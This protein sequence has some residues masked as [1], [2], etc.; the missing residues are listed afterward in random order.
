MVW[1]LGYL[2]VCRQFALIVPHD[3]ITAMTDFSNPT[4]LT[5]HTRRL[6][7]HLPRGWAWAEELLAAF[8]RLHALPQPL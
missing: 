2:V 8:Q 7:L 5:R 4:R 3:Q 6:Q 1:S